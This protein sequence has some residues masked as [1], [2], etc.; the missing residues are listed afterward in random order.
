MLGDAAKRCA[1]VV[2]AA[3]AVLAVP[4]APSFAQ[5]AP[6]ASGATS[7]TQTDPNK[8]LPVPDMDAVPAGR[9]L[10]GTQVQRIGER[11]PVL[12][13]TQ[14]RHP[15]SFVNVYTK[16]PGRWQVSL[17]TRDKPAKEVAQLYVDDATG[18]VTEAWTGFQV[19][20]TMAR[21]YDGA[22]GRKINSPW[23]WIPLTVAFL[24]P[25]IDR[26]RPLRMLH[27]DVLVLAAFGVSV[28][29]FNDAQIGVSVPIVYPLLVYLMA[30]MLWIG[31]RRDTT[32]RG[33]LRLSV[34]VRWLAVALVFLIGFRVALNVMDSNVI[35]VGYA[36][37]IG[38]DRL[39]QGE[40]L[41]GNFPTDNEHGDTYGPVNYAAYLPFEQA[42]PWKG[43]WD[44]LPAA[45]GAAIAFDLAC[46][47]LLFFVG[48]RVRGPDLGIVLAYSWA[49]FPFT[50]YAMNT[51]VNDA[52]VGAL[53]LAALLV[54]GSSAGRGAFIALA[55]MAKFAPLALGPV[56]LTHGQGGRVRYIVSFGAVLVVSGLVV[57][58]YGDPS[59]FYDRTLGFQTSRGSPFSIWGLRDWTTAQ[60]VVQVAGVV[61]AIVVAV[62]P[63]RRDV[64]GLA[65]LAAAV[66]MGLELGVTHWFYLYVVWFFGP[67]M[68]ALLG[69]HG[70][71]TDSIPSAR[72][73]DEQRMTTAFSQGSS[74]EVSNL[75]DIWVR[76]DSMA[77]SFLTPIT[78][79]RGPVIPTS[80]I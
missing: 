32:P 51:N 35:D 47:A 64:V 68:L 69:V 27:L 17:F 52:L 9:R 59:T 39:A 16:G 57:L 76:M 72:I 26:R 63:R 80:V 43:R 25:F 23:V 20:W 41:W 79:P 49:A 2:A 61:L 6:R 71:S 78:P 15:R 40:Q 38:A 28:A 18:R 48:R 56:F 70:T 1:A 36:G 4:A 8:A 55:G 75:T 3:L 77:C 30:R 44:D 54:A 66:M 12:V 53:V 29:F 60:N 21:G 5:S 50:L 24:V 19:A 11:D 33:P 45:H 22:F 46:L 58:G 10:T 65:A 62:V 42:A 74:A 67:V 34:P 14:R 13:R 37:V 7:T 73:D 31:L